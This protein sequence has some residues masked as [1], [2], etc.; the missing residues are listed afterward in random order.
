VSQRFR[1][2]RS[3]I[4]N[5]VTMN[6]FTKE[7]LSMMEATRRSA[8][9]AY[10]R[11]H[12]DDSTLVVCIP[13][14]PSGVVSLPVAALP[15]RKKG[16]GTESLQRHLK[17]SHGISVLL[18]SEERPSKQR[19]MNL[20][21]CS[22]EEKKK[23]DEKLCVWLTMSLQP[24]SIVNSHYFKDLMENLRP[25]YS[26]AS[27]ETLKKILICNLTEVNLHL[28]EYLKKNLVGGALSADSW[29][30]NSKQ[31]FFGILLHFIDEKGI[32]RVILLPK[33][34]QSAEGLAERV[35]SVLK[36]WDLD[37]THLPIERRKIQWFTTDTTPT[38]PKMAKLLG[39]IWIPCIAHVLNLVIGDALKSNEEVAQVLKK[40][41]KIC[42]LFEKSPKKLAALHIAQ[43][44]EGLAKNCLQQAVKTRW[45][46]ILNML[47][48][49]KKNKV[50]T[51]FT[52]FIWLRFFD[53]FNRMQWYILS[54]F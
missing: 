19:K 12:P 6:S 39:Y 11:K 51:V 15:T 4:T 21:L 30:S 16:T 13:C 31:S 38:M 14:W 7:E 34:D 49:L 1:R 45:N 2:S 17:G 33:V 36:E 18:G 42:T 37:E 27:V 9:W 32:P 8:V 3:F 5:F 54:L 29:T 22:K 50:I 26:I 25:G 52:L 23:Y 24:F 40:C 20:Y 53:I 43:I 46:S 44:S 41:R 35:K 48:S 28:K 47:E 10:F